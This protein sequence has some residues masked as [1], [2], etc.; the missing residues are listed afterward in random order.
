[1]ALGSGAAGALNMWYDAD[2]DA[3]MARTAT[4]PV[5][6]GLIARSEALAFGLIVSAM[7][8]T[9]MALAATVL[10]ALLLAFSIFF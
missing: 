5:P 1:M 7:S 4:R 10:A 3:L 6:A 8:V 2:I 9:L